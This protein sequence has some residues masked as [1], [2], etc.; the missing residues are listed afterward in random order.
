MRFLAVMLLLAGLG[1][2]TAVWS[3]DTAP[4]A[5]PQPIEALLTQANAWYDQRENPEAV[6]R[7]IDLYQQ[8]LAQDPQHYE[9]L[10]RLTR[11]YW[12]QGDHSPKN[13]QMALY[14]LGEKTGALARAAGP[15][16]AEGHYWF[17][18]CVGRAGEVR[19]VLNSLFAVDTIR[20][21][22]EAVLAVDPQ[23]GSA[24]HVL[25]V[26]YRKAPGWPLSSGDINK[27]LEHARKA[28]E[29]S[30]DKVLPRVGLAETLLAKGEKTEAKKLLEEALT[31]EGPADEQPETKKDKVEAQALLK[32][33]F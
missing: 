16:Q 12:W 2:P 23:H 25:G 13:Q 4:A 27:S 20:K 17:G 18:V 7:A 5:E 26:L 30:P 10:W 22:M 9:A 19:G 31:L 15:Q 3:A 1:C 29:L 21:A 24:H 28:V 33:N 14:D 8:I 11:C 6:P 32:K